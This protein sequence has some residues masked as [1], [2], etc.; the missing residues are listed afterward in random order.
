M[1]TPRHWRGVL[2]CGTASGGAERRPLHAIV[3]LFQS[4]SC[5]PHFIKGMVLLD[6]A[7]R[8]SGDLL[9]SEFGRGKEI[10]VLGF[11]IAC[12]HAA[13]TKGQIPLWRFCWHSVAR[14]LAAGNLPVFAASE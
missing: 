7:S 11:Q 9:E 13:V 2:L 4:L 12:R 1:K 6:K 10:R 8:F 3:G 5:R 14:Q